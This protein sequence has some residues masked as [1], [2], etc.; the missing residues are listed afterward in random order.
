MER[1]AKEEGTF[2]TSFTVGGVHFRFLAIDGGPVSFRAVGGGTSRKRYENDDPFWMFDD[3]VDD[4]RNVQASDFEVGG[5]FANAA[6]VLRKV[7][8]ILADWIRA[9]RPYM[10]HFHATDEKKHMCYQRLI[11]RYLLFLTDRYAHYMDGAEFFFV[12]KED[13]PVEQKAIGNVVN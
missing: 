2:A 9:E 13:V 12:R 3:D 6:P 10:F 7:T 8:E 5:Y 1:A 11:G 4:V